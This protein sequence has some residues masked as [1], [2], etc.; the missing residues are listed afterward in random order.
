[1]SGEIV[2]SDIDTKTVVSLFFSQL[3]QTGFKMVSG[4]AASTYDWIYSRL[5]WL[6]NGQILRK[7]VSAF[8]WAQNELQPPVA[9]AQVISPLPPETMFV[10]TYSLATSNSDHVC[11]FIL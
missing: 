6:I 8:P 1:M 2:L 5:Q 10:H 11:L 7:F 9:F 3:M 4:I